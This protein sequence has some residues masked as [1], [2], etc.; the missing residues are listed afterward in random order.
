MLV[1]AE[2]VPALWLD[3]DSIGSGSETIDS[4]TRD[5]VIPLALSNL[6]PGLAVASTLGTQVHT[7]A[8]NSLPVRHRIRSHIQVD[9]A[10]LKVPATIGPTGPT[11]PAIVNDASLKQSYRQAVKYH[12]VESSHWVRSFCAGSIF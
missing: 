4:F 1:A 8:G 11:S 5:H 2:P 12:R 7:K 3:V 6:H 10:E 9:H